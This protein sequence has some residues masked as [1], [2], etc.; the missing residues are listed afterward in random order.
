MKRIV[1]ECDICGA[2]DETGEQTEGI[3]FIESELVTPVNKF[4]L[5]DPLH[6]DKHICRACKHIFYQSQKTEE[7]EKQQTS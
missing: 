4:R 1:F 2:L 7:Y 6:A 3:C 5:V